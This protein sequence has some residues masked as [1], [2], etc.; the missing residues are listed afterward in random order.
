MEGCWLGKRYFLQH[1]EPRPF[2]LRRSK[3]KINKQYNNLV[4]YCMVAQ[5]QTYQGHTW[6][7]R[8]SDC[9][10]SCRPHLNSA[11]LFST[12][13]LAQPGQTVTLTAEMG[14]VLCSHPA[15][16]Y[17]CQLAQNQLNS[18][19]LYSRPGLFQFNLIEGYIIYSWSQK[20]HLAMNSLMLNL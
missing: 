13:C 10:S 14:P 3:I 15:H 20:P 16:F 11:C 17:F 7:S 8:R 5:K 1:P 18:H 19:D 9:S 12:Q 2:H 4:L 6:N